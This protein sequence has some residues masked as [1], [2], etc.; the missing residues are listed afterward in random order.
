VR[1]FVTGATGF[2]GGYLTSQLLANGHDVSALVRTS[3]QA[4]AL[5]AYGV[6][7]H[8]GDVLDKNSMRRGMAGTDGVFHLAAIREVGTR[9]RKL[10]EAV[11]IEGTRNVLEL[12][13]ELGIPRGVYTSTVAVNSDTRGESVD[14]LYRFEG[15]HLTVYDRTKAAAHY[16]VA[17]PMM[18]R[19]LPLVIVMPGAAYGPGDQGDLAAA[20]TSFLRGRLPFVPTRSACSFAHVLDVARGH[21]LA[22]ER[23]EIG[24]SYM[25]CGS[26]HTVLEVFRLIAGLV[27][28]RHRPVPIPWW[29]ARGVAY[30]LSG[31][32]VLAPPV[33]G[34][35]MKLRAGAGVT[36]LGDD[37]KARRELGFA[38]QP[39]EE[40]LPDTV[41]ALLED[42][43]EGG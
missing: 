21:V 33:R 28:R 30:L 38:P 32:G 15:R 17:L 9:N 40:G 10:M 26:P 7:P 34:A 18:E 1:Y 43:F 22:M 41:R 8:H 31:V 23:G 3:E 14:E 12:M 39:L 19:G 20:F 6:L 13:D 16:Q 4:K 2:V 37:S 25:V 35:A 5:A 42:L 11:N 27:G 29:V 36:Y 24:Q